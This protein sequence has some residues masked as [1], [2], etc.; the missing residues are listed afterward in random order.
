MIPKIVIGCPV[1]NR[2]WVLPDYLAALDAVDYQ[3]KEYLF[4]LNNSTDASGALLQQFMEKQT[5]L[6]QERFDDQAPG[7]QRGEYNANQFKHLAIIR[8]SFVEM[9]LQTTTCDYLL[10]IDSDI[11]VP[12]DIIVKMLPLVNDKTIAAAAISNIKGKSLDGRIPGNFMININ[13]RIQHPLKYPMRDIMEVDVIGAVYLI[14]RKALENNLRYAPHPQGEDVAFC[15]TAK[16]KGYR[17]L[18]NLDVQCEHRMIPVKSD[19]A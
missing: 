4:L 16:A 11:I 19:N 10:S 18:V 5:G 3:S 1:R 7:Y 15:L 12:P 14:P 8:N 17:L 13:G 6:L 2:A 9:F